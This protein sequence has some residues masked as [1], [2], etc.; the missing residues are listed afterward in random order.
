MKVYHGST[1]IVEKP[2]IEVLSYE[3]SFEKGF[4]TS[5]DRKTAEYWAEAKR[6]RILGKDK[7]VVLKKYINV[8]EFTENEKLNILDFD[9]LDEL[10]YKFIAR[11]KRVDELLHNYDIVKGSEISEKLLK[12]LKSYKQGKL[13]KEDLLKMLIIYRTINEV[14]FHTEKAIKTLKFLYAEEINHPNIKKSFL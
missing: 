11:N 9:K 12:I 5:I 6:R 2:N 3:T 4:Y 8:Y 13:K 7:N 14:S 1:V 10:D